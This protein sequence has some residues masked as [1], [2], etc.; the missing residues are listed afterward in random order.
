M[1]M[2]T[3]NNCKISKPIDEF[4]VSGKYHFRFCR[5]CEK[6][7]NRER[8]A[9]YRLNNPEER[10]KSVAK[11]YRKDIDKSRESGRIRSKKWREDNREKFLA[12]LKKYQEAH[13]EATK[14]YKK[15]YRKKNREKISQYRAKVY[16]KNKNKPQYRLN[17]FMRTTMN[18]SLK[19]NGGS[20][21]GR[22]WEDLVGYK[23]N[24]LKK[25]LT[26]T[27]PEGYTWDDYNVGKLHIDHIIPVSAHNFSSPEH[28][29]FLNCWALS[30]LQLLP[31][32]ENIKKSNKLEQS[33]QPSLMI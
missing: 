30:N 29:D 2:K 1:R 24:D 16:N 17:K 10:K 32:S 13:K 9:K 22:H 8:G 18:D 4:R 33:F 27:I 15:E 12:S 5:P 7:Y 20:K 25:R 19:K 11:S 23:L 14:E 21:N 26:L 28:N 6:E 31:A 3:C